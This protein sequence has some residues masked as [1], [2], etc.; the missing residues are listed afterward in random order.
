MRTVSGRACA[1]AWPRRSS[2]PTNRFG[3]SWS[4]CSAR[5]MR[6]SRTC[7]ASARRRWRA[8]SPARSGCASAASSARRTCCPPTSPARTSSTAARSGSSPGRSSRTCCWPT[9]STAPRRAT[10]SALLEAMQERQVTVEGETRPLPTPF[11]VL[12]TQNPIELEGTFPL[13]EAQLDR[14]LVRVTLGYPSEAGELA[15]AERYQA[16]AEPLER[17]SRS[18]T[19]SDWSSFGTPPAPSSS[20]TGSAATSSAGARH[21]GASGSAAWREPANEWRALSRG[22]GV[23]AAGRP[24][25]HA[26]RRCG[27]GRTGRADASAA[28]RCRPPAAR[29]ERGSRRRGGPHDRAARPQ[30]GGFLI[31]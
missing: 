17:S 29:R 25:V 2:K 30:R 1:R 26:S 28:P 22:A 13:P 4:R 3:C 21:P 19:R 6:C 18:P 31:Q 24:L 7:R 9:R 16:S 12:A 14:F 15:I 11:L 5:A 27:R 8:R 10:Q 20:A 23:G